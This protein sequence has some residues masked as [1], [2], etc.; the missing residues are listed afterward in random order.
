MQWKFQASKAKPNAES[1]SQFLRLHCWRP[2]YISTHDATKM[3]I[4]IWTWLVSATPQLG[5]VVLAELVDAWLWRIDTKRWLF[6]S[7]VRFHG[8]AAKLRPQLAPGEPESP[9]EKYPV[10]EI[11]AHRLWLGFFVDR[12][13]VSVSVHVF[14]LLQQVFNLKWKQLYIWFFYF[15]RWFDTTM[16]NN[17]CFMVECYKRVKRLPNSHVDFP[18]IQPPLVPFSL[19]CCLD[20]NYAHANFRGICTSLN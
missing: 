11:L 17:S 7:Q 1:F 4:F 18:A 5:C 13:E 14:K 2:T 6:A 19:L 3:G 15:Y 9:P 12:F 10:Q 8:P 16:W 20:L